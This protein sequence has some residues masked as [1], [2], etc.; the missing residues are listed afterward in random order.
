MSLGMMEANKQLN[1]LYISYD[2]MTDALG[3]SQVLPYL[4]GIT[5][6]SEYKVTLLSFEKKEN[7]Q[8]RKN[9]ITSICSDAGIDWQPLFYT[10]Q[11][12]ILSTLYDVYRL[13]T[14]VD[15]LHKQK[16]FV[17]LHCRSYIAALAGLYMK[18]K[19]K[20]PFVFDMRG[21][22]ADERVDGK[23]WSLSNPI[24]KLIYNYFKQ[25]EKDFFNEADHS[26]SLTYN[27]KEEI[28]SWP[29]VNNPIPISVIPCCA[30]LDLF[31]YSSIVHSNKERLRADLGIAQDAFVLS[32]LGSIGTWYM[33]DEMLA[34]FKALLAKK[35][36]AIFLFITGESK[37]LILTA[38]ERYGIGESH[39][40]IR[41]AE[42]KEVPIY[43]SQSDLAIFFILPAY[44]KKASSPT[45]QGEIMGMGIPL[46]CNDGVGD[47][48]DIVKDTQ[49]G[50]VLNRFDSLAI[51]K[52]VE[53]VDELIEL[54]KANIRQGAF[55]YYSLEHGIESYTK[56]YNSIIEN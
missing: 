15:K 49:A 47:T 36:N 24:Y 6:T 29:L 41:R 30:D 21:F 56:I 40:V 23:I 52:A 12:P 10:K 3:Q 19:H 48:S 22:W 13:F 38:A 8:K 16:A 14:I 54:N 33:L 27:A 7:Y 11:P 9:T 46:V 4:V 34:F 53:S 43:L 17:L 28:H 35:P 45:K 31:D 37:E 44:S 2:G 25:K 55:K 18:R 5:K 42:R 20:V 26:V 32:Y 51:N 1:T 50:L 39:F